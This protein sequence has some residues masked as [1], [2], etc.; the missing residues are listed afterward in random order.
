[1]V[2]YLLFNDNEI[3]TYTKSLFNERK[4]SFNKPANK[5]G[6]IFSKE[7]NYDGDICSLDKLSKVLTGKGNKDSQ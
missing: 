5:T 4:R 2:P 6:K 1:M 7:A 3:I